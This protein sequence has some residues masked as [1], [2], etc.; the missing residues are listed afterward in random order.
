MLY[1]LSL[2]NTISRH[3]VLV[4]HVFSLLL[5]SIQFSF[6]ALSHTHTHTHRG[7]V[8]LF[9]FRKLGY[10]QF[11]FLRCHTQKR[12][13][14]HTQTVS[15]FFGFVNR[16]TQITH[17][18][19]RPPFIYIYYYTLYF[20]EILFCNNTEYSLTNCY[21]H[22]VCQMQLS[23]SLSLQLEH[24]L[25]TK[26]LLHFSFFLTFILFFGI[27]ICIFINGPKVLFCFVFFFG[28]LSLILKVRQQK[29]IFSNLLKFFT[30]C[31]I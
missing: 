4:I 15:N 9:R 24:K 18:L 29:M 12:T 11:S 19:H 27:L 28:F 1:Y 26:K 22:A 14:K 10:I 8:K 31:S 30:L 17:I 13:H 25:D 20:L 23:R 21:V 2:S 5:K 7:G 6:F 3:A 16:P